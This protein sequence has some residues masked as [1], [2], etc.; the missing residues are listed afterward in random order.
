MLARKDR[1]ALSIVCRESGAMSCMEKNVGTAEAYR[2]LHRRAGERVPAAVTSLSP[3]T[4]DDYTT[5][6]LRT[7]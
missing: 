5:V 2:S 7:Q 3:S 1:R 6:H 4:G